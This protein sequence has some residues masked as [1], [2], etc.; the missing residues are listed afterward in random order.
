MGTVLLFDAA[1]MQ[2]IEDNSVVSGLV[3]VDGHL[4]LTQHDG[5]T[6]DAGNVK[7]DTGPAGV[8]PSFNIAY[9]NA[10]AVPSTYAVGISVM[11]ASLA[12]DWPHPTSLG[13]VITTRYGANRTVQQVFEKSTGRSWMRTEGPGLDVWF[14][15]VETST[16]ATN[17]ETIAGV[18]AV[19]AVTPASLVAA[20]EYLPL[21]QNPLLNSDFDIW[22]RGTS[23]TGF[24]SGTYTADRWLCR[25]SGT[26]ATRTVSRQTFTPGTAPVAGYEGKS[27]YRYAQTVAGTGQALLYIAE[28]RIE[29]VR[30]YAGKTVTVSFWAK[31]DVARNLIVNLTQDFG[32]GGSAGVSISAPSVAVT[33]GWVRYSVTFTLGSMAGKTIADDSY[34]ALS[35]RSTYYN[36]VQTW[37]LWGVQIDEGSVAQPY[38]RQNL[39]PALELVAC[40]RYYRRNT[41]P[42]VN[43]VFI[44]GFATAG[45]SFAGQ[46]ML[47]P[48]MRAA[49]HTIDY[50]ST[51]ANYNIRTSAS[52][53]PTAIAL[54]TASSPDSAGI[55]VTCGGGLTAGDGGIFRAVNS[56]AYLGLSAEL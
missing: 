1:R 24:V 38:R 36:I 18:N 3:D 48:P 35:F 29:D 25:F 33:T 7:G 2:E 28:H 5:S 43:A 27:F 42:G 49:P 15:W 54:S 47:D 45:T 16:P 20:L 53:T 9:K 17:A 50:S 37:D 31:A 26:G 6:M 55:D 44:Q 52:A 46:I 13:T 8:L 4:I 51:M 56:S 10:A 23:F 32:T 19:K 12:D 39:S 40:R 34:L 11:T 30:C 14:A 41:A 22:Q 21:G